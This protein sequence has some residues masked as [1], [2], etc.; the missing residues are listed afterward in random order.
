MLILMMD[1]INVVCCRQWKIGTSRCVIFTWVAQIGLIW[2][3]ADSSQQGW[4][5][6]RYSNIQSQCFY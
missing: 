1:V 2:M 5:H 3:V 4:H 6:Q